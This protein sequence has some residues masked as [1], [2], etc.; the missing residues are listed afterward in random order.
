MGKLNP[1]IVALAA[2]LSIVGP[3]AAEVYPSRPITV[4]V[5][6]PAGGPPDTLL[7]ILSDRMQ[8]S[9]GQPIVIENAGGAGGT[10]AV[11]RVARQPPTVTRSASATWRPTCSAASS[12][13]CS[14]TRSMTWRP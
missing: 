9:L 7:R 11:G 12:T 6:G 14:M 10:I 8:A 13:A 5:P 4:V 1:V 3:A 2:A